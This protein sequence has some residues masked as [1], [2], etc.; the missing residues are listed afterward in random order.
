M[1]FVAE[2]VFGVLKPVFETEEELSLAVLQ[3]F[4]SFV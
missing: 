1:F 3:R 4:A 2:I